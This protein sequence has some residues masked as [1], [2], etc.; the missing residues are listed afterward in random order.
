MDYFGNYEA[1]TCGTPACALGNY[2]FRRDLQKTF[3]LNGNN[4]L[5]SSGSDC[6]CGDP[7]EEVKEH[8]GISEKQADEL[9]DQGGC[10]NAKTH[11][12]AAKYIEEFVARN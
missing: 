8:F 10:G 5:L 9:F 1:R 4:V 7:W 12:Q 6:F 11:L 2:A 3:R